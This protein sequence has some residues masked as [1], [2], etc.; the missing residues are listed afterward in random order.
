MHEDRCRTLSRHCSF[1][2]THTGS[3][4]TLMQRQASVV[5]TAACQWQGSKHPSKIATQY[6]THEGHT[7][8]R[9]HCILRRRTACLWMQQSQ[10]RLE[11][12]EACRRQAARG[13]SRPW[14]LCRTR[15]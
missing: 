15:E 6:H 1:R 13:F 5:L 10:S 7:V 9:V 8:R 3:R 12:M 11:V 4:P 2:Q 14:L